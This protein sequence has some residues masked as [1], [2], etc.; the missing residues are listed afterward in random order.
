MQTSARSDYASAE[1]LYL[2]GRFAQA[3]ASLKACD[4]ALSLNLAAACCLALARVTDAAAYCHRAIDADPRNANAHNNL[5]V[6]LRADGRLQDAKAAFLRALEIA[7]NLA[8][9][10][11]NLGLFHDALGAHDDAMQSHRRALECDPRDSYAHLN[12]G[13]CCTKLGRYGEAEQAFQ[14][15]A[16]LA[17]SDAQAH[18]NHGTALK[19]LVRFEEAEAAYRRALALHPDHIDAKL[20]LAHLLLGLGTMREG[21][22]LFESRY[23]PGGWFEPPRTGVPMWQGE[24]LEGKSLIVWVE[25]G[26]GDTLQF[27]RYLP[28]LKARGVARLSFACPDALRELCLTI[29]GVD[30]CIG[31]DDDAVLDHDYQCM[32]MSLPHR[33]GTTLDS[34]PAALPY[35]HVQQARARAWQDRLPL[36]DFNVG[37]VWAG[38]PRSHAAHLNAVDRQRSLSAQQYLPILRVPGVT[39]ISLQKGATTQ[40]QIDTLPPDLRPFDPMHDVTDFA[41]TAAIIE[42][43]D[44]VIT[45]DTS[46]AHLAGALNKPVWILSRYDGCWRWLYRAERTSPWYP[47]ARLFRQTQPGEWDDVIADVARALEEAQLLRRPSKLAP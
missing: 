2:D 7:P 45:V 42:Q 38:D 20:N 30:A 15:A 26:H 29:E 40:P 25:Q 44:L 1:A 6:A 16:S 10:H 41:D 22:A 5:G 35:L 9:A 21:W 27:C 8:N 36:G 14:S 11:S 46:V 28:M 47:K 19:K 39:F 12:Y 33:F 4:D 13:F 43:L 34:V 18:F 24:P 23:E 37:L 3:L 17:P 31:F 32:L